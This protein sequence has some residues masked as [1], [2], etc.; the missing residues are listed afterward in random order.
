MARPPA[1][2]MSDEHS[3]GLR[4][5]FLVSKRSHTDALAPFNLCNNVQLS[6]DFPTAINATNWSQSA[7]L[8][9]RVT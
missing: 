2:A 8:I 4:A 6:Y 7:E 1:V 3:G 5:V 9:R